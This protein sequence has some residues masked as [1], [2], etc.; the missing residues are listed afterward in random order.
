MAQM[1]WVATIKQMDERRKDSRRSRRKIG[2]NSSMKT[3]RFHVQS[4]GRSDCRATPSQYPSAKSTAKYPK[5]RNRRRNNWKTGRTAASE[6]W[7]MEVLTNIAFAACTTDV[8]TFGHMVDATE[9]GK[10]QLFGQM[11]AGVTAE[12]RRTRTPKPPRPQFPEAC[13]GEA[14]ARRPI[15]RNIGQILMP[16]REAANYLTRTQNATASIEPPYS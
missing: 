5:R 13:V 6:Q 11:S 12:Q 14:S 7:S 15:S 2:V 3:R 16:T 1:K 9:S 8:S 10:T 4:N